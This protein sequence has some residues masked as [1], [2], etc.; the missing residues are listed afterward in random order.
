MIKK[1]LS[2]EE[3]FKAL[4]GRSTTVNKG[5]KEKHRV[6]ESNQKLYGDGE[7][8]DEDSFELREELTELE[9]LSRFKKGEVLFINNNDGYTAIVPRNKLNDENAYIS[10]DYDLGQKL[11]DKYEL[12]LLDRKGRNY[13]QEIYVYDN[14]A[15]DIK[16]IKFPADEYI[17]KIGAENTDFDWDD[18]RKA[19]FIYT[20][21]AEES[22]QV[23]IEFEDGTFAAVGLN[24][25]HLCDTYAEMVDSIVR[26]L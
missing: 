11:I 5:E 7:E 25:D 19:K 14:D 12:K 3:A 21:E 24:D 17:E 15:D 1:G 22:A 16:I 20:D 10:I 8:F 6:N 9:A 18:G 4:N 23:G 26:Y 2:I 13:N